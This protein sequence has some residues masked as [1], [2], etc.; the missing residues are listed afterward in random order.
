VKEPGPA[1]DVMATLSPSNAYG[2]R[3][4]TLV[5]PRESVGSVS[6]RG[7]TEPFFVVVLVFLVVVL[8][9]TAGP[10]CVCVCVCC[11]C[12]CVCVYVCVCVCVCVYVIVSVCM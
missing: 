9:A 11:V 10:L 3:E 5:P 6:L 2:E 8:V 7:C 4:D 1:P 12:V